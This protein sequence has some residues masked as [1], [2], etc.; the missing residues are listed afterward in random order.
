MDSMNK[1]KI[2]IFSLV[3]YPNFIGGAEVAVK[4]ITDRLGDEYD[5]D[6]VTLRLNKSLPK[7]EKIGNV[8]VHRVGFAFNQKT[9]SDSLPWYININKYLM[10]ITA[11]WVAGNLVRK[12]QYHTIWS[13]MATYNSFTAL[14]VKIFFPKIK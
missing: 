11:F 2:L 10:P 9:S 3:Y 5:F 1:Q 7:I 14:L 6:M 12:N 4:E 8:T 13:I